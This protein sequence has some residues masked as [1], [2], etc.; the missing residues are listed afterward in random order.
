MCQ[1]GRCWDVAQPALMCILTELGP[2]S[3]RAGRKG[4]FELTSATR[5]PEH[6]TALDQIL[7][8]ALNLC[9]F[10]QHQCHFPQALFHSCPQTRASRFWRQRAS[11]TVWPRPKVELGGQSPGRNC[12]ARTLKLIPE[13]RGF[14]ARYRGARAYPA[15]LI[16]VECQGMAGGIPERVGGVWWSQPG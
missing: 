9:K 11:S 14:L 3:G 7:D 1:L 6:F 2:V 16:V 4:R 5:N 12:S 15:M 13:C 8:G 10:H